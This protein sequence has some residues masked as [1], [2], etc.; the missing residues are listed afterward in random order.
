MLFKVLRT[1]A[2]SS[3]S[4]LIIWAFCKKV[5]LVTFV[6]PVLYRQNSRLGPPDSAVFPESAGNDG[7]S[8]HFRQRDQSFP[9]T[10]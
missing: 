10:L 4:G 8:R 3:R 1:A 7:F 2:P 9:R 6:R 5:T